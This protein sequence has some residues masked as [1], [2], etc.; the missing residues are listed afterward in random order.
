MHMLLLTSRGGA[1]FPFPWICVDLV[2]ILGLWDITE[3]M[4]LK[5]C[6]VLNRVCEPCPCPSETLLFRTKLPCLRNIQRDML[7]NRPSWDPNWQIV[8]TWQSCQLAILDVLAH[9]SPQMTIA[10]SIVTGLPSWASHHKKSLGIINA[11]FKS[12]SLGWFVT[13]G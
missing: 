6:Q 7:V 9:S 13:Q 12:L 1:Y 11:P 2:T 4:Q 3:E 10:L 5:T 8:S